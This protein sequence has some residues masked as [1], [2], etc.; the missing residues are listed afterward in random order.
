M[1]KRSALRYL[2]LAA[3]ALAPLALAGA[4]V[5]PGLESPGKFVWPSSAVFNGLEI[6]VYCLAL[7][8][9]FRRMELLNVAGVAFVL[10]AV[11]ALACC[12]AAFLAARASD[13][14]IDPIPLWLSLWAGSQELAAAQV[15]VM[16]LVVL[17][18]LGA[19]YPAFAGERDLAEEEHV[20]SNSFA[21]SGNR[22]SLAGP[23]V[24]EL[25]GG[26]MQLTSYREFEGLISRV[27][28]L[29]GYALATDE[30][31][32]VCHDGRKLSFALEPAAPRLQL[33]LAELDKQQRR[34]GLT[35]DVLTQRS[36]DHTVIYARLKP[37][38]HLILFFSP[39]VPL[40][41]AHARLFAIRKSAEAFLEDRH[42]PL[43]EAMAAK[44]ERRRQKEA[45]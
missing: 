15:A 44:A 4:F 23:S 41:E 45:A 32:L 37:C 6:L 31:L 8:A 26:S 25:I 29:I 35:G 20:R 43:A 5:F 24:A 3:L 40:D 38:F 21:P 11:R 34:C 42:R 28:H 13:A 18:L 33:G 2:L 39:E 17:P 1:N 12:A 10:A 16:T 27:P 22:S 7:I 14:S 19:Y 36:A 9:S 30:G